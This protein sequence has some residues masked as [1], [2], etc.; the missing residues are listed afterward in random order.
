MC[1][2][3]PPRPGP[4]CRRVGLGERV[5][6]GADTLTRPA[7]PTPVAIRAAHH[8]GFD[9][10]VFQL[11]TAAAPKSQVNRVRKIYADGSGAQVPEPDR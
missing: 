7:V 1:L 9:R 2:L 4:G 8:P 3:V 6:A 10:I 11:G 5:R